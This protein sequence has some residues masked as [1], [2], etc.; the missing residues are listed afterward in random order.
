MGPLPRGPCGSWQ[1]PVGLAL[2]R[3]LIGQHWVEYARK[4][5][6]ESLLSVVPPEPQDWVVGS[7]LSGHSDHSTKGSQAGPRACSCFRGSARARTLT[8]LDYPPSE[9]AALEGLLRK[10]ESGLGVGMQV[11]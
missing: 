2:G 3:R 7:Q 5:Q 6:S 1:D 9:V 4:W 8:L 11:R 10:A